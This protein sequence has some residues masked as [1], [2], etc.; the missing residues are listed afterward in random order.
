MEDDVY[1]IEMLLQAVPAKVY[2]TELKSVGRQQPLKIMPL[3]GGRIVGCEAVDPPDSAPAVYETFREMATDESGRTGYQGQVE[4]KATH[5]SY[6]SPTLVRL[7]TSKGLRSSA[8]GSDICMLLG[9]QPPHDE[10]MV[11]AARTT[12]ET[13]EPLPWGKEDPMTNSIQ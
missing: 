6:Q 3:P 8:A 2:L 13:H 10:H 11:H 4:A 9:Q 7:L 12:L 5:V 1:T